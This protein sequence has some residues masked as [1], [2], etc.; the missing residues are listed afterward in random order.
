MNKY[1]IPSL[2]SILKSMLINFLIVLAFA[3]FFKQSLYIESP[4]YALYGAS[5]ITLFYKFIRP[6]FLFMSI[7][8]IIM[9][10]GFFIVI[11]NAI[12]ILLVSN[13][14]NP[15]FIISSFGSAL[16]LAIFISIFNLFI[17]SR[18]RKII[19]KRIK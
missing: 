8:P 19:I 6:V 5:L 15:H 4:I 17:N 1:Q 9:T 2:L 11:I 16:G 13:V 3:G 12:I 10:F 14:L 18:D 7:V